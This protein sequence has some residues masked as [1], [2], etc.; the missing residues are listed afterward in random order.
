MQKIE[1]QH[2]RQIMK[3]KG[4]N[5]YTIICA[6]VFVGLL[7]LQ[8]SARAQQ[9]SKNTPV[10]VTNT[11]ANPVPVAGSV[12]TAARPTVQLLNAINAEVLAGELRMWKIDVRN[13]SKVRV[14]TFPREGGSGSFAVIITDLPIASDGSNFGDA[15]FLAAAGGVNL[16]LY[17]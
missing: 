5:T 1:D 17:N 16:T 7:M 13:F 11:N 4:S 10:V 9:S 2:R 12:T 3:R 8:T 6:V 14:C 15:V